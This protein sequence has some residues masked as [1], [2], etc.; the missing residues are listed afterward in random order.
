MPHR[1]EELHLRREEREL[2]RERQSGLEEAT[3]AGIGVSFPRTRAQLAAQDV[4]ERVWRPAG[5][6]HGVSA[7]HYAY[8]CDARTQ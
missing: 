6:E 1:G 2:R 3:L 5:R 4:L 8:H 7:R